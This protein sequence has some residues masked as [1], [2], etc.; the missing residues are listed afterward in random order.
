MLEVQTFWLHGDEGTNWADRNFLV[1]KYISKGQ[2]SGR[3]EATGPRGRDPALG[4]CCPKRRKKLTYTC[5]IYKNL[6]HVLSVRHSCFIFLGIRVTMLKSGA[7]YLLC[8]L[9]RHI[10]R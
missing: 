1:N 9:V 2:K 4:V 10:P 5:P 3:E 8:F 6:S 7:F